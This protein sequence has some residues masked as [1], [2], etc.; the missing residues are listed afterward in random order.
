ML[1]NKLVKERHTNATQTVETTQG[2]HTLSSSTSHM[3][4]T[5]RSTDPSTAPARISVQWIDRFDAE[6]GRIMVLISTRV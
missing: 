2:K 3:L 5:D 4:H 1:K 6:T